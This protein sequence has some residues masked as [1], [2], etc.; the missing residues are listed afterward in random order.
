VAQHLRNGLQQVDLVGAARMVDGVDAGEQD[1]DD[2]LADP[3]EGLGQDGIA[4]GLRRRLEEGFDEEDGG[5]SPLCSSSSI[6]P[7]RSSGVSDKRR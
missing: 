3:L 7:R 5:F 4:A 6:A 2:R 1:G